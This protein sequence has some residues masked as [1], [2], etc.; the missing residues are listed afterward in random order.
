M[1][2]RHIINSH[3]S[4]IALGTVAVTVAAFVGVAYELDYRQ[5]KQDEIDALKADTA[6]LRQQADSNFESLRYRTQQLGDRIA[7]VATTQAEMGSTFTE[8]F[9]AVEATAQDSQQQ[10]GDRIAGVATTQAEMGSTFTERFVAVEATAQD[11]QQ[12]LGGLEANITTIDRV[13]TAVVNGEDPNE[14]SIDLDST[15][16][17]LETRIFSLT[18]SNT[19]M[20]SV[21]AGFAELSALEET[22]L[23]TEINANAPL[24]KRLIARLA[25]LRALVCPAEDDTAANTILEALRSARAAS[26]N[27]SVPAEF[28]P[29]I[30]ARVAQC[31]RIFTS[32][33][34]QVAAAQLNASLASARAETTT[35]GRFTALNFVKEN[36]NRVA[37]HFEPLGVDVRGS[38]AIAAAA[39]DALDA[40]AALA[41]TARDADIARLNR[42]RNWAAVQLARFS[43]AFNHATGFD[44]DEDAIVSAIQMYLMPIDTRFLSP[45]QCS[46]MA[47]LHSRAQAELSEADIVRA[48][49]H[50]PVLT[51]ANF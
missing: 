21:D 50:V 36:S 27:Y 6:F 25:L 24:M 16:E 10:L 5:R 23:L 14:L 28:E 42:Y 48:H 18:P 39:Q 32:A 40:D 30:T 31:E 11:S 26:T 9:V 43:T 51:P 1:S 46:A 44:D 2:V 37:A 3:L 7:G 19:T 29:S 12:Q 20:G 49:V 8:R 34:H 47:E 4:W 35:A 22:L 41:R 45:Q 15:L 38:L 17:Q 33:E 13:V